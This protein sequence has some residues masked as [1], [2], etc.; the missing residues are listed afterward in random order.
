[1]LLF[2]ISQVINTRRVVFMSMIC[3][4]KKISH[5]GLL[6]PPHKFGMFEGKGKDG[7][8]LCRPNVL[9]QQERSSSLRTDRNS[10]V[11]EERSLSVCIYRSNSDV[12]IRV[13]RY[14]PMM[15]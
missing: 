8:T 11:S 7:Y 3:D 5:A 13:I 10:M 2:D 1:M 12:N 15:L 14:L 9:A 4:R 6:F